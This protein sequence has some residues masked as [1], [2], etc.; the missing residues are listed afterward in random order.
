MTD[1]KA[2]YKI[3]YGLYVLTA[4]DAD[5]ENGC[6]INTLTQVTDTPKRVSVTV[7]KAN[8][9]HDMIMRTGVFNVSVISEKAGFDLFKDF[10]YRSG[11]DSDKISGRKDIAYAENGLPYVKENTNAL[12]CGKVINTID[13]GTHTVFI[14]DVTEAKV[15]SDDKSV[16]YEYYFANIK[17]APRP[18]KVKGFVC[19]ICGYIYEGEVLPENFVCP[20]CKHGAADFEPLQ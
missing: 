1:N 18:A 15:I 6:I 19:K 20:I 16:T 8:L 2:F 4:K 13:A 14:A 9:T 7:N 17:P 3:S 5:K 12:I 10:G 11:K